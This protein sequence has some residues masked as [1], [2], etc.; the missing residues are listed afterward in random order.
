[1]VPEA[2]RQ[3]IKHGPKA[4]NVFSNFIYEREPGKKWDPVTGTYK[5]TKEENVP[6]EVNVSR[7][8][9]NWLAAD[10]AM[11]QLEQCL[12]DLINLLIQ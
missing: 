4:L 12:W 7:T 9:I 2:F 10:F 1:M 11:M 5:P 8:I 3:I 6:T